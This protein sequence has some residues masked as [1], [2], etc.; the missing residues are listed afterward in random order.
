MDYYENTN[1]LLAV[2]E[3]QLKEFLTQVPI[4]TKTLILSNIGKKADIV[5]GELVCSDNGFLTISTTPGQ[6]TVYVNGDSY[7][8]IIPI[9]DW[10]G[11]IYRFMRQDCAML[12]A[13]YLD[14]CYGT[15]ILSYVK[16]VGTNLYRELGQF[17]FEDH[18]TKLG[19]YKVEEG[20]QPNDILFYILPAHIGIAQPNNKILHHLPNKL[21]CID[22]IDK[23][24]ILGV[25]RYG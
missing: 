3:E 1:E 6:Y 21:S 18:L 16:S 19:F 14:Q 8:L 10:R 24:K 23:S 5:N 25:Y 17:G 12:A 15:E 13:E 20:Y 4:D 7:S 2:S 11:R 22:D 9:E